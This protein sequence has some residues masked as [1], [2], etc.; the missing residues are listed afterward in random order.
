MNEIYYF[1]SLYVQNQHGRQE[2]EMRAQR[3]RESIGKR[4]EELSQ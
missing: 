2:T 4:I 1:E 3:L